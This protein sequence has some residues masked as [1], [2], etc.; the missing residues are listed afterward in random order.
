MINSHT[1]QQTCHA[2]ILKKNK[3]KKINTIYVDKATQDLLR[4]NFSHQEHTFS[5]SAEVHEFDGTQNNWSDLHVP[6]VHLSVP[7]GNAWRWSIPFVI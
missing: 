5:S 7:T 3:T 1:S 4:L 6:V 2:A